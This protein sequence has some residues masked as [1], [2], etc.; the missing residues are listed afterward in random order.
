MLSTMTTS[1]SALDP[2]ALARAKALLERPTRPERL[3]PVIG[4]AALLAVSAVVFATA[5]VLA[6][7]LVSQHL[8][9]PTPD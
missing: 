6:P 9:G 7:P 1:S 8:A 3:W 2:D 4:A 5:M